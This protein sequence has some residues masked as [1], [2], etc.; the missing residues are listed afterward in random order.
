MKRVNIS[1]V[2]VG[3]MGLQH[4]KAIIKSKKATIVYNDG[5]H[6]GVVGI[7]ASRLIEE[8]YKPTIVLSK[9]DDELTGSARSVKG[10]DLYEAL[11]QCEHLLEK[12][13]GHKYAAGLTLKKKNLKFLMDL[14]FQVIRV[15]IEYLLKKILTIKLRF[16]LLAFSK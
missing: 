15:F 10:F 12:F 3:L 4:I 13:G 6:K 16:H 11:S 1:I 8:H 5:W 7:V 14:V 2:G 9:N